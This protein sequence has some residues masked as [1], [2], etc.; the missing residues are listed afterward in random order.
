[1]NDPQDDLSSRVPV[2]A[3]VAHPREA[4]RSRNFRRVGVF[5]LLVIVVA[6]CLGWLGPR[7]TSTRVSAAGVTLD[8]TH[9]AVARSGV[10]SAIELA[11]G[12]EG[13]GPIRVEV[14]AALVDGLGLVTFVPAPSAEAVRG[15]TYVLT[16]EDLAPGDV[17][18][19]LTGRMPTR[20]TIGR[21]THTLRVLAGSP[22]PL[23]VTMRTWVLP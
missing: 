3:G 1:M 6:A 21:F 15:D 23:E 5:V 7:D 4:R 10:D 9:P 22:E 13:A 17:T 12:R 14:P 2:L 8:A 20:A 18:L 11:V 16:Y 19:R